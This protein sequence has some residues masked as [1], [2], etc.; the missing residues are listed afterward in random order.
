[1]LHGSIPTTAALSRSQAGGLRLNGEPWYCSSRP[2]N[3][4]FINVN[5]EPPPR[6]PRG[7]METFWIWNSSLDAFARI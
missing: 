3:H 2:L 4:D 7:L 6:I 1:M 5:L